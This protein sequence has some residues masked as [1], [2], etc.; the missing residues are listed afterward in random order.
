MI[1]TTS[2]FTYPINLSWLF[3]SVEIFFKNLQCWKKS[4]LIVLLL[5][6]NCLHEN[7][8]SWLLLSWFEQQT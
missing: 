1:E 7:K 3:I 6:A 2:F 8:V 5:R 4:S